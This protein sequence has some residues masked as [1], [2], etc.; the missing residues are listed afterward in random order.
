[1]SYGSGTLLNGL[2]YLHRITDHR[3]QGSATK[4]L[5][6]FKKLCGEQCFRNVM[7]ATTMWQKVDPAIGEAREQELLSTP[8]FW[9]YMA[10]KGSTVMRHTG[11]EEAAMAII[12]HIVEQG[13][14]VVLD[15]QEEII[16]QR[17]NLDDTA[18]AKVVNEDILRERE[19]HKQQ[20]EELQADMEAAMAERDEDLENILREQ[21]DIVQRKLEQGR[22]DQDAL[23]ANLEELHQQKEKEFLEFKAKLEVERRR[24]REAY[25]QQMEVK[26]QL[27]KNAQDDERETLKR[28][29]AEMSRRHEANLAQFSADEQKK[30]QGIVVFPLA[31]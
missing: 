15:I 28:E 17:C 11:D 13:Q 20:L 31:C 21:R 27:M 4:N 8:E 19:K 16:D 14:S 9:G 18:A 12:D 1:M 2:I 6:M 29:M 10:K 30:A 5:R 7:L 3:M 23:R 25:E 22:R 24:E 26:M